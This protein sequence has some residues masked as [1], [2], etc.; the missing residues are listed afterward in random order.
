MPVNVRRFGEIA[1]D[2]RDLRLQVL[3][4]GINDGD[5]VVLVNIGSDI[6]HIIPLEYSEWCGYVFNPEA[7]FMWHNAP[8]L[9]RNNMTPSEAVDELKQ[10]TANV[11][12][13]DRTTHGYI[14]G[15]WCDI[16]IIKETL[17]NAY[18]ITFEPISGV[19]VTPNI[20]RF[21]NELRERIFATPFRLEAWHWELVE[22]NEQYSFE[23]LPMEI[24]PDGHEIQTEDLIASRTFFSP[25]INQPVSLYL[26]EVYYEPHV[27]QSGSY[28][29]GTQRGIDITNLYKAEIVPS[30]HEVQTFFHIDETAVFNPHKQPTW[31]LSVNGAEIVS[32]EKVYAPTPPNPPQVESKDAYPAV[33]IMV[34]STLGQRLEYEQNGNV[35]FA[36][37]GS[38]VQ[39]ILEDLKIQGFARVQV[40]FFGDDHEPGHPF[41]YEQGGKSPCN[42]NGGVQFISSEGIRDNKRYIFDR[43]ENLLERLSK[44]QFM[45]YHSCS[46]DWHKLL[47]EA[48]HQIFYDLDW[49]Q[50]TSRLVVW[51]GQSP[52]HPYVKDGNVENNPTAIG[53]HSER[54]FEDLLYRSRT[55]RN[56]HHI[57][58]FV[59]EDINPDLYSEA[60]AYWRELGNN[61]IH[62]IDGISTDKARFQDISNHVLNHVTNQDILIRL[63]QN[64]TT[65]A[66]FSLMDNRL[67][68]KAKFAYSTKD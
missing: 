44:D 35:N 56:I 58:I 12:L 15:E 38:L 20:R 30:Q 46:R 26:R 17:E 57:P 29:G 62:K 7:A 13:P 24:F 43:P 1:R 59:T 42:G 39:H 67:E 60:E 63:N 48:L 14:C 27:V 54:D 25:V 5:R 4:G 28:G 21:E 61:T 9:P 6:I 10:A 8:W 2:I 16:D 32:L 66:S 41:E 49:S 36:V 3:R 51:I 40:G 47:E 45:K 53:F 19:E 18:N 33:V 52:P 68:F 50:A 64:G 37:V 22:R 55:E 11:R 23:S 31:D 65:P 34:E